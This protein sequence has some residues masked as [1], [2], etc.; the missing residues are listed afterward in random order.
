MA[1]RLS[2]ELE[3]IMDFSKPKERSKFWPKL[4]AKFK[5]QVDMDSD[6]FCKKY[7]KTDAKMELQFAEM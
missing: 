5:Y 1:K 3:I 2:E 6:K 4:Q 7:K